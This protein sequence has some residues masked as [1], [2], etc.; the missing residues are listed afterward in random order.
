MFSHIVFHYS[1]VSEAFPPD[2]EQRG[3]WLMDGN[4][5]T[6]NQGQKI[7]EISPIFQTAVTYMR[8][9]FRKP[10][11][12]LYRSVSSVKRLIRYN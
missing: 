8:V 2:T 9:T 11:A 12:P 10:G 4:P 5:S 7:L 3:L 1:F 6:C